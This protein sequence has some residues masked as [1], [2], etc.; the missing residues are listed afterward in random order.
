MGRIRIQFQK[1]HTWTGWGFWGTV[2]TTLG[3]LLAIGTTS[4]M[5][6]FQSRYTDFQCQLVSISPVLDVKEDVSKLQLLYDSKDIRQSH[7]ALTVLVMRVG[8]WGNQPVLKE[9]FD[10]DAPF[11]I[12]MRDARIVD[13]PAILKTQHLAAELLTRIQSNEER[14]EFP[15]MIFPQKSYFETLLSQRF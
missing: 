2:I 5:V 10:E 11:G 9:Y 13:K 6:F 3:L 15:P 8:N 12:S 4:Y 7:E 14:I 1:F